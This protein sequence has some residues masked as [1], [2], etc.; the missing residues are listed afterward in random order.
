MITNQEYSRAE[1][2]EG[3][4]LSHRETFTN[5]YL[6]PALELGLI[7]MTKPNNPTSKNQKYRKK[8]S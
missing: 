7:E 3:L 2:M 6:R 5:N 1:L 4:N 8:E